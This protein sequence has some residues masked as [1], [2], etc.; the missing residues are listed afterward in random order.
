MDSLLKH[1]RLNE[2][3]DCYEALLTEKQA[4]YFKMYYFLDYSLQEIALTFELSR[5]A[6]FDTLKK[7]EKIL[8]DYESKLHLLENK[9]K[10][11][12][13]YDKMEESFSL[14]LLEELKK[15]D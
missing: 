9:K 12:E 5:N 6:I 11:N 8:E 1:E 2:L 7:V 13:I 14:R 15:I 3:F 10:R 4:E